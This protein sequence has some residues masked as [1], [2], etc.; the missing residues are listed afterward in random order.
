MDG[1]VLHSGYLEEPEDYLCSE[2]RLEKAVLFF[3][4]R[5]R[6][7]HLAQCSVYCVLAGKLKTLTASFNTELSR[8][9]L[10][11]KPVLYCQARAQD[12]KQLKHRGRRSL[13]V[14]LNIGD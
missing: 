4:R 1:F 6:L 5:C 2:E 3:L 8:A 13:L 12:E 11:T 14:Q 10:G 9:P 7:Y